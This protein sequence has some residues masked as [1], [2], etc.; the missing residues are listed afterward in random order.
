MMQT[1]QFSSLLIHCPKVF[2]TIKINAPKRNKTTSSP[3]DHRKPRKKLAQGCHYTHRYRHICR[4]LCANDTQFYLGE[5]SQHQ[6]EDR[7]L[8]CYYV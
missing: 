3:V 1:G 5:K 8:F 7:A 6:V 2:A 4:C